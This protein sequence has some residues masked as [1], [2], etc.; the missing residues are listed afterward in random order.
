MSRPAS[1]RSPG[2]SPR[3]PESMLVPRDVSQVLADP[4]GSKPDG[5]AMVTRSGSYTYRELNEAAERAARALLEV[6]VRAGDRV[7]A[8]LPNDLEIVAA[9]H[10]AMRIGAIWVGVSQAL[11]PPEKAYILQDS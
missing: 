10:G 9:F 5:E 8:C 1:P 7:A 4:L 2:S 11:A 6:G 3:A